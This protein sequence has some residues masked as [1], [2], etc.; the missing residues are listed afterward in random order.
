MPDQTFAGHKSA[1]TLPL[2]R[3]GKTTLPSGTGPGGSLKVVLA[4]E[5]VLMREGLAALLAARSDVGISGSTG[6]GRECVRLVLR[7]EPDLLIFDNAMAGLNGVE[8]ARRVSAHRPRTRMLCLSSRDDA[9]SVR[10]FFDAGVHGYLAKRSA[11]ATLVEAID[12]VFRS[13]YFVS[14]D[15]AHVLVE[16][17]RTR[18]DTASPQHQVLTSREREVARLY[19]EGLSTRD[20]ADRLHLSMKTVG[21]H[22]EHLMEKIGA[23]SI[24]HLTRYAIRQGLVP[25]DD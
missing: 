15:I 23:R 21:S 19:A 6:D 17:F 5:Q 1:H 3:D 18:H 14:P 7:E 22:R 9:R 12:R 24:A 16:G 4:D 8:V 2:V 25:L 11:F 20:I 13:G 10:E